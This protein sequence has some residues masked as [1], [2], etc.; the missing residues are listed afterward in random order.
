MTTRR[1]PDFLVKTLRAIQRQSVTDFEVI[2]SD[3]DIAASGRAVVEGLKDA[4]FQYYCNETDVGML[5]SFN[6]SLAKARG[7]FVV[8][9]TDDDPIYPEML[10]ILK[11]LSEKHPGYGC[12]F[13]GADMFHLNPDIAKITLHKVGANSCLAPLPY[14]TVRIYSAEAFPHA[15]FTGE[16]GIYMLWSVGI[17]RRDIAQTICVP[18]YGSPYMGDLAYT[19]ATCSQAGCVAINTSV[20]CQTVHDFNFGRKECGQLNTAAV[21]FIGWIEK[22]IGTRNDW[23]ALKPKVEKFVSQ[24]VILHCVFLREYFKH[25][26]Q[27]DSELKATLREIYKIPFICGKRLYYHAGGAFLAFQRVQAHLR[28]YGMRRMLRK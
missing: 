19:V 9:I 8:M 2:I 27:D 13:G 28:N 21:G 6:R 15:F 17:T 4:R 7:K 16:I 12:Y 5:T 14:G 23:L 26:K 18:D 11:E 10:E 3:N 20:G 25:T 1:R 22:W 24:W